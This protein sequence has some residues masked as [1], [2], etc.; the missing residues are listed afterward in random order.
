MK[1]KTLIRRIQ[2][3]KLVKDMSPLLITRNKKERRHQYQTHEY[4][5]TAALHLNN[6]LLS[7]N[8]NT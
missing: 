1:E 3:R 5:Q 8:Y 6:N 4:L 7:I 2:A